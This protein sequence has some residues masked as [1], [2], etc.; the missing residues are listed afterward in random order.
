[1]QLLKRLNTELGKT[2]VMVTHDPK[3]AA[4]ASQTLHLEKGK[5]AEQAVHGSS[6]F[7][8]H[9]PHQPALG[10]VHG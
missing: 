4:Y 3:V 9:V 10:G 5:L 1:M 8:D 2:L 6:P 7:S